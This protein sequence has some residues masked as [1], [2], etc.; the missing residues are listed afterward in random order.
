LNLTVLLTVALGS[1]LALVVTQGSIFDFLRLHGPALS[2]KLFGCPLC[3]GVWT[4]G[5]LAVYAQALGHIALPGNS[6]ETAPYVLGIAS[7]SGASA[8]T[9]RLV[10]DVLKAVWAAVEGLA[11]LLQHEIAQIAADDDDEHD[12][13]D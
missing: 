3:L 7:L 2:R 8:L 9:V 5:A 6:L 1:A 10:W 13:A 4:G 12:D 11:G